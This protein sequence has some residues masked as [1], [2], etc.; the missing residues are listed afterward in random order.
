MYMDRAVCQTTCDQHKI[1]NKNI[2]ERRKGKTKTRARERER[3]RERGRAKWKP[4]PKVS[5]RMTIYSFDQFDSSF[6]N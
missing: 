6:L 1:K 2:P 5:K 3:E 4:P